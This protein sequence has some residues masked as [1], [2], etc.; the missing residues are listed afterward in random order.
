MRAWA[1]A[2]RASGKVESITTRNFPASIS[3]QTFSRS[4]SAIAALK[5]TSRAR[6]VEPV[7][8]SR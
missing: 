6:S 4:A 2:T 1:S 3:G 5:A 8:V 7:W